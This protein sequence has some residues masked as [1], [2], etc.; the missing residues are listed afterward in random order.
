[1]SVQ[2]PLEAGACEF[3]F[4]CLSYRLTIVCG[5]YQ[6]FSSAIAII[7][8]DGFDLS[9]PH[10][11]PGFKVTFNVRRR[12]HFEL[13]ARGYVVTIYLVKNIRSLSMFCLSISYSI[14]EL[15]F[16]SISFNARIPSSRRARSSRLPRWDLSCGDLHAIRRLFATAGVIS[17]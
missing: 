12:I 3:H 10:C 4:V 14:V 6:C 11:D 2:V 1:M 7:N 13:R 5:R 8:L 17:R 15:T 16:V 9:S